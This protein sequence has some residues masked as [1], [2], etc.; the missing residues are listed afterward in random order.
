MFSASA[1]PLMT[2]VTSYPNVLLTRAA[3]SRELRP[4]VKQ[5]LITESTNGYDHLLLPDTGAVAAF[6]FKGSSLRQGSLH[7]PRALLS[8][9]YDVPRTLERPARTSVI[10]VRFT[11]TGLAPFLRWSVHN[12]FDATISMDQVVRRSELERVEEQLA[13]ASQHS[14]RFFILEQ[15]L[16]RELRHQ[17]EP[18]PLVQFLV[19]QIKNKNGIVRIR[20]LVRNSGL[21]QSAVERRFW[22]IMGTTP[23]KFAS[24]VRFRQVLQLHSQAGSLTELAYRAGY[25]DQSHFIN[26]FR[27]FTAQP[28]R[29]FFRQQSFC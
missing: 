24:I 15:F 16:L 14:E 27:R 17:L 18:D 10:L 21:S 26:D 29:A 22:R 1:V 11:E 13:E 7:L 5:F 3:P 23:R 4:F 25:S 2:S 19:K 6:R 9:M 20:D 28:P 8:G 12:L